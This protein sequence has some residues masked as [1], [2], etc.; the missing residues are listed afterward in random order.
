[1]DSGISQAL[2]RQENVTQ[3][4][5][6]TAFYANIALGFVSYGLLFVAA[7]WIAEFYETPALVTLIR[8][9]SLSVIIHSF[10]VVQVSHFTRMLNFKRQLQAGVPASF[11][12]GALAVYM[13]YMGFEVWALVAHIL[14][15]DFLKTAFLWKMQDWR[16]SW[17]FDKNAL[18]EMYKFGYKL[19]LSGILDTVFKNIYVLVIAKMFTVSTTGLYF[20]A[21]KI[22]ELITSQ[23]VNSIQAVT[24]PALSSMQNDD[25]RLKGAYKKVI[26]VTTFILFPTILFFAVL[27][28][29]LFELLLPSKWMPAVPYLQLM[30]FTSLMY[31]LHSINLNILKVKGRSDL[32]L[33]LEIIKK[34]VISIVL[35]FSISYGI[36]GILI[37]QVLC[38]VI[39][40]IPNSYF[41]KK[42]ISY[43][44]TEQL[45]DFMP[46]LLLSFTIAIIGYIIV[47]EVTVDYPLLSLLL[48]GGGMGATYLLL[49]WL[50]KFS[51]IQMAEQI[52]RQKM[53]SRT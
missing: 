52:I 44:I 33:Y 7:P 41:S 34:C 17:Q 3:E 31:P 43:S 20:F 9:A 18:K 19:F 12:S 27:A 51:A 14:C 28:G 50:F 30:C 46:S 16:P 32:F 11:L 29:P 15:A 53:K 6:S 48:V 24:Y 23:L 49:A 37:G 39:A 26:I 45:R 4:I 13:A 1:M 42:V 38:S 8:V 22:R 40:Y 36:Y 2:I 10:Q 21:D 25:V 5:Y 47:T 35:V